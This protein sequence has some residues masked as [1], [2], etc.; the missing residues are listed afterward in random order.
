MAMNPEK[1]LP[2]TDPLKSIDTATVFQSFSTQL[3]TWS[4]DITGGKVY[5]DANLAKLFDMP[6]KLAKGG[7]PLDQFIALIYPDDQRKVQVAMDKTLR[8]HEPYEAEYRTRT[9]GGEVR[10]VVARGYVEINKNGEP[11]YFSGIMFDISDRKQAEHALRESER[12]LRF[13][14]D[15]MP[16]L[17]WTARPDGY[18][19]Y[20]NKRWYEF[21]GSSLE[22]IEGDGWQKLV[23]PHDK[24]RVARAWKRSYASGHPYEIEYR[25]YH[26]PSRTYRWVI[27]RAVPYRNDAGKIVSWYGTSTDI[28]EQKRAAQIQAFLANISKELTRSLDYSS[29]LDKVTQLC[30]PAIADWCGVDLYYRDEGFKQVSL[31]HVNPKKVS[32]ARKHRHLNRIELDQ[33][34]GVAKVLQSGESEYYPRIT[35]DMLEDHYAEDREALKFMKSLNIH[36]VIIAPLRVGDEVVGGISFIS[37]DSGRYYTES[38]LRMAE[39]LAGRISLALTNSK[40]YDDSIRELKKRQKVERELVKEKQSLEARVKERTERR[41]QHLVEI[42]RSKDEF[43]SIASHQLRTPATGVKQYVGMILEGF[44]GEL[45]P[46]QHRLLEKAYESNERQLKIV[47]DL[48][49]VAQVDAG[50]VVIKK[51]EVTLNSFIDD[52]IRDYHST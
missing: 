26:A 34:Y 10:W 23:H 2:T 39:E 28:H 1:T 18:R 51:T 15:Q 35:E 44:V 43:I 8:T 41:V 49:R 27:G 45:T 37:S 48:L 16:Q 22:D 50:K 11:T 42:N 33:P 13:M 47:T 17:S 40:L 46:Q 7:I 30:V 31:A 12:R 32:L 52:V 25:L 29:M 3:G 38:D 14:A 4:W 24:G 9:L 5:T 6:K 20:F 36:S 21:T 19:D